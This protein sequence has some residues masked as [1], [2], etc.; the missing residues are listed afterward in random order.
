MSHFFTKNK[1][2]DLQ[3][4]ADNIDISSLEGTV[5]GQTL[6]AVNIAAD[7]DPVVI[8]F[9]P[10]ADDGGF[11]LPS[12]TAGQFLTL[13][14][15]DGDA[16]TPLVA[17]FQDFPAIPSSLS[18]FL[19]PP[20][21][22]DY[23]IVYDGDT[24]AWVLKTAIPDATADNLGSILM[25]SATMDDAGTVGAPYFWGE[26]SIPALTLLMNPAD[27]AE[28]DILKVVGG[29]WVP[30]PDISGGADLPAGTDGGDI[31]TWDDTSNSWLPSSISTVR[32]P[33]G[34]AE[35]DLLV[36]RTAPDRSPTYVEEFTLFG[37]FKFKWKSEAARFAAGR[38][39]KI[40]F[41]QDSSKSGGLNEAF[42][43]ED[44]L[45]YF[46]LDIHAN[47]NTDVNDTIDI[48]GIINSRVLDTGDAALYIE[49]SG[50]HG[51]TGD[52]LGLNLTGSGIVN[53]SFAEPV[54]LTGPYGWIP[55]AHADHGEDTLVEGT[56]IVRLTDANLNTGVDGGGTTN[57]L[58]SVDGDAT[59]NKVVLVIDEFTT[60]THGATLLLKEGSVGQHVY[61][62]NNS[63]EDRI[64]KV[65]IAGG[66]G[67]LN[68]Y[69][70]AVGAVTIPPRG[71]GHFLCIDD[72][73][74]DGEW[75][76]L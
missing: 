17:G 31:L 74:T 9:Q 70:G 57:I 72:T 28:G 29:A 52:E 59:K 18:D 3:G 38:P 75:I 25:A 13:V 61:V 6:K 21:A 65:Q 30:S 64:I 44:G 5:A 36:W 35:G 66:S 14:D 32:P 10:G 34:N 43:I 20:G 24:D 19:T 56:A 2:I 73:D 15:D 40:R 11:S 50:V 16:D 41:T 51:F 8:K 60:P 26:V 37:G 71:T 12:G 48:D 76:T 7:G 27:Q 1:Q 45:D 55:Q 42:W 54:I 53:G 22:D 47:F 33:D 46:I 58:T 39:I 23:R 68:G 63:D 62:T 69:G 49:T 4:L 67:T